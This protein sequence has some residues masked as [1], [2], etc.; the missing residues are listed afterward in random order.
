VAGALGRDV[1]VFMAIRQPT[2]FLNAAYCQQLMG[3]GVM[4]MTEYRRI[5]PPD[6]V[7]WSGLVARLRA[8]P[9]VGRLV[10]WCHEDYAAHFRTIC[11]ELLGPAAAGVVEPIDRYIHRSLSAAGVAEVLH[12][13]ALGEKGDLGSAAR[14]L[15]P[16]EDGYPSFDGFTSAE[17]S[18]CDTAYHSQIAAIR[19]MPGVT[20]LDPVWAGDAMRA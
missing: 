18:A 13:H 10:V 17:H 20:L 6:S 11:A 4:S 14:R 1:D 12:R 2:S 3:S 8:A 5:N 15:L 7:D 9:G 19:A 16:V